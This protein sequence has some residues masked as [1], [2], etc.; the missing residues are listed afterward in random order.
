[1]DMGGRGTLALKARGVLVLVLAMLCVFGEAPVDAKTIGSMQALEWNQTTS[2][3]GGD[4]WAVIVDT[5]RYWLNYRHHANAMAIYR[6]VR[7]LGIPDSRI[8]LM[9]AEDFSTNPR[10]VRE[11]QLFADLGLE[12]DLYDG[13]VEVDYAG[14]EVS[15]PNFIR[16]LTD[17][18]F[19]W[20]PKSKRLLTTG[21]N[22][23]LLYITGHG[24]E[25]F[26]KFRDHEQILG[27]DFADAIEEMH[28]MDR[29][30]ELLV[31]VDT[32]KAST[33]CQYIATPNVICLGSSMRGENS[34]SAHINREIGNS[35]VDQLSYGIFQFLRKLSRGSSVT[36]QQMFDHLSQ[37][38]KSSTPSI[39][40]FGFE[41][42]LRKVKVLE[43][44]GN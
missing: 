25:N 40:T 16:L 11:G 29:F 35:L 3:M 13:G 27:E 20:I 22:N 30:K 5:S 33:F 8:I 19:S 26:M 15:V 18:H 43:F 14:S 21:K 42:S 41:R 7:S 31:V 4:A 38:T 39:E 23:V 17:R 24:G 36:L 44:F 9:V 2:T 10:N 34:Y 12:T 1:M 28:R 37:V 32:C 6:S